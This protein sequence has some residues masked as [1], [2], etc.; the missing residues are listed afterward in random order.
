MWS[1]VYARINIVS[2]Y[3]FAICNVIRKQIQERES[4]QRRK[5]TTAERWFLI[6][7]SASLFT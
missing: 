5:I 1:Q 4:I 3:I 2:K 6:D 7:K